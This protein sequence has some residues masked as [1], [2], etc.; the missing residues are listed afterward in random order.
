MLMVWFFFSETVYFK[1]NSDV[2]C[3]GTFMAEYHPVTEQQCS[4]QQN[5][6]VKEDDP[7]NLVALNQREEA[8]QTYLTS[9]VAALPS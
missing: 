6:V 8:E 4:S 7:K 3:W 2:P 9:T 5:G 1:R